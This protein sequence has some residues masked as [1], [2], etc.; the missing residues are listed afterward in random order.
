[1]AHLWRGRTCGVNKYRKCLVTRT[2]TSRTPSDTTLWFYLY[3]FSDLQG[4]TNLIL[5]ER[6]YRF[7]SEQDL[8][9]RKGIEVN[10][11]PKP[12]CRNFR[13]KSAVEGYA[14]WINWISFHRGQKLVLLR[15]NPL[16]W[17]NTTLTTMISGQSKYGRLD[18]TRIIIVVEMLQFPL[19]DK[20]SFYFFAVSQP[21]FRLCEESVVE[22][23]PQMEDMW[24]GSTEFSCTE[25]R[26]WYYM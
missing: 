25:H 12:K 17:I 10:G 14:G 20:V 2:N 6:W 9:A 16:W 11:I 24:D 23:P 8:W 21:Q 3:L 4:S 13:E 1:M 19:F 7:W 26:N 15:S 22:A 18:L 5:G